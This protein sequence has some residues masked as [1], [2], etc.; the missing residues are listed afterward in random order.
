MDPEAAKKL[1]QSVYAPYLDRILKK[2]VIVAKERAAEQEG[3]IPLSAIAVSL[4]AGMSQDLPE[5]QVVA[6]WKPNDLD[7]RDLAYLLTIKERGHG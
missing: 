6:G 3:L 2:R 4:R 1:L 7:P 5:G